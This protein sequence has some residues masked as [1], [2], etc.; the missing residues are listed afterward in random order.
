VFYLADVFQK[1]IHRFYHRPFPQQYLVPHVHQLILHVL[2]FPEKL[3]AQFTAQLANNVNVAAVNIARSKTKGTYL[4][5]AVDN[6]MQ[7]EAVKPSRRAFSPRRME[8]EAVYP[9]DMAHFQG[10]QSIKLMPLHSPRLNPCVYKS[11][12]ISACPHQLHKPVVTDR[13]GEISPMNA[14]MPLVIPLEAPITRQMKQQ[15][16]RHHPA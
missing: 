12:G 6:Q 2:P 14:D 5:L 7:F 3:P 8:F 9:P 13:M 15:D 1:V 4:P 16:D 11:K 10:G